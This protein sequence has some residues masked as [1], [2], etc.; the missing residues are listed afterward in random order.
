M[1]STHKSLQG[2][3]AIVTGG[4]RGI[5][6]GIALEL[7]KRGANVLITYNKAG[8][9][10]AEVINHLKSLGVAAEGVQAGGSDRDSPRRI[11]AKCVE[12]WGHI[13]II[14]NNAGAGDDC[15]LAD[16]THELWDKLLD[17]N[18]RFPTFLV[19]EALPYL[20][21]APRIVNV[22]SVIARMGGSYSTAYCATKAALEG[23]TKVWA[24][25]LGQK[26]GATVNCVNPGPVKADMW[27][28]DTDQAV[29]DEWDIK[30][31]E[32]PAGARIADV[33][34]IAQIVAFLSEEGSRWSTGSTVNANGGL[35]FV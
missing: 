3:V 8:D 6:A 13:D 17:C 29:L 18:L 27:L 4:S 2:R 11:V 9:Q 10:A 12:T 24:L 1:A 25:E 5:G 14:I 30:M 16:M 32:T 28:R 15:L 35:C 19:K 22:S 26:Y 23:V 7:A 34:D 21:A 20:G 31:K 33:D